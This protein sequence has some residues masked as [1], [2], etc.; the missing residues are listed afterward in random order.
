MTARRLA[1]LALAGLAASALAAVLL[2]QPRPV[3]TLAEYIRIA[4]SGPEEVAI[5]ELVKY[6]GLYEATEMRYGRNWGQHAVM[7]SSDHRAAL[8]CLLGR[9]PTYLEQTDSYSGKV[10]VEA[11]LTTGMATIRAGRLCLGVPDPEATPSATPPPV[12]TPTPS[13][14]PPPTP[15]P[16]CPPTCTPVAP[17]PDLFACVRVVPTKRGIHLLRVTWRDVANCAAAIEWL[18]EGPLC[19][20]EFTPDG[21]STGAL[22]WSLGDEEVAP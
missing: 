11:T 8:E 1:T 19:V 18:Q 3:I 21:R 16:K 5:R 14:P 15:C 7:H 12:V 6:D 22:E 4:S 10:R 13:L 9:A 20:E 2:A 17:P